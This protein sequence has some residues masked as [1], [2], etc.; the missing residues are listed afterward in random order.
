MQEQA[1]ADDKATVARALAL[2]HYQADAGLKRIFRL[3]GSAE[4]EVRPVEPI[5]LLEV[6]AETVASGALPVSFGAAPNSGVPY[7]S[8]IVEVSPEEFA[9]IQTREIK[10]PQGWQLGEEMPRPADDAG[11]K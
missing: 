3:T 8:I 10:L 1:V 9:K 7:P 2:K 6:N 4:A 11:D 5:K